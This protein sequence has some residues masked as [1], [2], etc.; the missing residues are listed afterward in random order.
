MSW[1]VRYP[2]QTR[3]QVWFYC[4]CRLATYLAYR[5]FF[6]FRRYGMENLPVSG[7]C[8][9]VSN[10]QSHLDPPAIGHCGRRRG[11]HFIARGS[12]FNNK[13]FA[14]LIRALNSIPIRRGEAD[15]KAIKEALRRLDAGA[16][17]V[18]FAE[19]TRSET[20]AMK[21]FERGTLLLLRK[22]RCPVV[23]VAVEGFYDIWPKGSSGPKLFGG[24]AAIRLGTPIPHDEL[25]GDGPDEA[26]RR[27]AREIDALRLQL[28]ATLREAS[29]GRFPAEG[30]GDKTVDPSDWYADGDTKKT[31]EASSAPAGSSNQD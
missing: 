19:G 28:R 29:K 2:L 24:R 4:F 5:L 31:A 16:A 14:W 23:P 15:L 12:L 22:S 7:P 18:V 9:L 1:R 8:I 27:L 26:L 3:S 10:H 20:G 30:A 6:R 25:M 21:V 13:G 11:I 17:V